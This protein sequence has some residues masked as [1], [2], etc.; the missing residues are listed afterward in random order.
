MIFSSFHLPPKCWYCQVSVY[1]KRYKYSY[2][3]IWEL[4]VRFCCKF[5]I[6]ISYFTQLTERNF[7]G[8]FLCCFISFSVFRAGELLLWLCS[9]QHWFVCT[10]V[11]MRSHCAVKSASL[12]IVFWVT[13]WDRYLSVLFKLYLNKSQLAGNLIWNNIFI[14]LYT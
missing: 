4:Y 14:V 8:G 7:V 2:S 13:L 6:T 9:K 3:M 11:H 10:E 1:S 12:T 5:L